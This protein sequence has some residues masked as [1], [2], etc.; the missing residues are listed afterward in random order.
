MASEARPLL[1]MEAAEARCPACRAS[2]GRERADALLALA[3]RPSV[4]RAST[5]QTATC[6]RRRE[7]PCP[8]AAP[9]VAICLLLTADPC[10]PK[11]TAKAPRSA[12]AEMPR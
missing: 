12:T 6:T 8:T 3:A 5:G 2:P 4:P 10:L 1:A 9:E 7:G 11:L